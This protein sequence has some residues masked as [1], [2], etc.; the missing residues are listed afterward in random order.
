MFTLLFSSLNSCTKKDTTEGDNI[1]TIIE[2]NCDS[3]IVPVCTISYPNNGDE[4]FQSDLISIS[5]NAHDTD[6]NIMDVRFYIDGVLVYS[7]SQPPY[8]YDWSTE[9]LDIGEYTIQAV[10]Q[11]NNGSAVSDE[12]N[13]E[14]IDYPIGGNMIIVGSDTNVLL[15]GSVYD[16]YDIYNDSV[17]LSSVH[18]IKNDEI[19]SYDFRVLLLHDEFG[20]QGDYICR[21]EF[22]PE[23]AEIG[24]AHESSVGEITEGNP[25][26][27]SIE[28]GELQVSKV[29]DIYTIVYNGEDIQ[30]TNISLHYSGVLEF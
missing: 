16:D 22:F 13:V 1:T 18:L 26:Y 20:I 15:S 25:V 8:N 17:H 9:G 10:A 14:I 28:Q 27:Y 23:S 4:F 24:Y 5:V 12:I 21:G 29:G 19:G 3:N 11:D 6:G 30:G 2:H 7:L